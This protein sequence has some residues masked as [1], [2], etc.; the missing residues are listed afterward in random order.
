MTV[1]YLPDSRCFVLSGAASSYAFAHTEDGGLRHLHWGGAIPPDDLPA[2]GERGPH[3]PAS[4]GS[5][6][7]AYSEEIVAW[8]GRRFDEATLVAEFADGTR[9]VEL[10]YAGHEIRDNT[11]RVRLTDAYYPLD[12]V[13]GYRIHPEHDV[14]VRW[15]EITNRSAADPVVL[16]QAFS[17]SWSLPAERPYR[18]SWLHG[19]WGAE[20]HLTRRELAP[21]KLVLESRTGTTGHAHQP[22][23]A[24]D[25]GAVEEHGEVWSLA[26]AYSGSWKLTTQVA[27]D[28]AVHVTGGL[29]DFDFRYRL[30]PGQTLTTPEFAGLYATAGFGDASRRWHAYQRAHVL[31]DPRLPRPVLFNSWEATAF[32]VSHRAQL[33][34][35]KQAAQLGVELFV[36]D[37][38]WFGARDSDKAGLGDWTPNPDKFPQGLAAFADDIHALGMKFGLWVEPEMVNPDSDLYRA[39]PDWI[40]HFPH[41]TRTPARNQH[42]LN[43]A[44]PDVRDWMHATLDGLLRSAPIDYLK[45]DMNRSISEPGGAEPGTNVW[46]EHVRNLYRVLDRLREDHPGVLIESCSG[47]GG[48]ADMGILRRTHQVWTSDNTDA[49]DRLRIQEG[50]SQLY[51]AQTMSCWVTDVPNFLTSRAI[52]L[53]FRFHTAMCGVLGIGGDLTEWSDEELREAAGYV[54]LYKRI[55]PTVQFGSVHRLASPSEDDV[56]AVGYSGDR[57]VVV[58]AFARSMRTGERRRAIRFPGLDPAAVYSDVDTGERHSGALLAHRGLYLRLEGDY[59]SSVTVLRRS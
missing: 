6:P 41:R 56:S 18:A 12:V 44:R 19:A 13:L 4:F 24:L 52:P 30:G 47:G 14:V 29:N 45:W 46:I 15:L 48:R 26:L 38:G 42:V 55:R 8:G 59:A 17:A 49:L 2:L 16:D 7:R 25:S 51:P 9:G 10:A 21:G 31:A 33:A 20:T 40:Y 39:H 23:L 28:G 43:L 5:A 11:L 37:D 22:W 53:R 27:H 3:D 50:Y 32:D 57:E 36:V 34:L 35:A 58:F 1:A 54:E